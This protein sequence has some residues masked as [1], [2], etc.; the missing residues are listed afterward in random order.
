MKIINGRFNPEE[1]N[2]IYEIEPFIGEIEDLSVYNDT[3]GFNIQKFYNNEVLVGYA[4][5]FLGYNSLTSSDASL[6]DV[7][8]WKG[9]PEELEGF[10]NKVINAQDYALPVT[11]F[12]YDPLKFADSTCVILNKLG[13]KEKNRVR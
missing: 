8:F 7:A 9:T 11:D 2:K 4:A 3:Y 13:F 1:L 6:E 12:Y 5:I 10:L